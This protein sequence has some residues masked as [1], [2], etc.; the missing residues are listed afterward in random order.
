MFLNPSAMAQRTILGCL[1]HSILPALENRTSRVLPSPD[2][3]VESTDFQEFPHKMQQHPFFNWMWLDNNWTHVKIREAVYAMRAGDLCLVAP[4]VAHTEVYS[5]T[6]PPHRSLWF[7]YHA[8]SATLRVHLFDYDSV[9][10]GQITQTLTA[11]VSHPF[12]S[13]LVALQGEV[14]H[15]Q[16][17]STEVCNALQLLLANY[18][19]R[20]LETTPEV[21]SQHDAPNHISRQVVNYLNRHYASDVSLTKVGRAL[22]LSPSYVATL[23][24]QETGKTINQT[25]TEIR[26]RHAKFLLTE[27][28]RAVG[29]VAKAVGF[30]SPEHFCR[31]F[32]RFEKV[33]PSSYTR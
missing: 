7:E 23:F 2:V 10:H 25:L 28:H 18:S 20:A 5:P 14:E 22:H 21:M 11:T 19:I 32:R 4:G 6:T 16:E 33:S 24:K 29:D 8:S 12:G 15:A 9:G 1:H 26:L 17:R 13:L 27:Q 3:A 31:V 30:R